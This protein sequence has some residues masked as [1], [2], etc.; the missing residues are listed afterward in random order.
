[1][2]SLMEEMPYR[3]A[4]TVPGEYGLHRQAEILSGSWSYIS[5]E[6]IRLHIMSVFVV[7]STP[8]S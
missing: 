4:V 8:S 3:W 2:I 5:E 1:M 6:S 7:R